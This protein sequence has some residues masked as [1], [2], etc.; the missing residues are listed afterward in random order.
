MSTSRLSQILAKQMPDAEKRR[1]ADWVVET[2][3]GKRATLTALRR[4][5]QQL[6]G[7]SP[8]EQR[9]NHR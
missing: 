8:T 2:G 7:K 3:L 4:V 1:R 5:L 9:P 6:R